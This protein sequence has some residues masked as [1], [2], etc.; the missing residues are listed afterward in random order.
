MS[1][2]SD[3]LHCTIIHLKFLLIILITLSII[4]SIMVYLLTSSTFNFE[5]QFVFSNWI[6]DISAGLALVSSVM[7]ILRERI[8][9]SEAKKYV[10]LFI[11]I[12]L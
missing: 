7:L 12:L 11:G 10:S 3:F 5:L 9:K 2:L 1:K 8:R 6:I 4:S